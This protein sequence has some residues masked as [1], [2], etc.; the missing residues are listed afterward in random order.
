MAK[1]LGCSVSKVDRLR[2]NNGLPWN[3]E[4]KGTTQEDLERWFEEKIKRNKEQRNTEPE[5]RQD[6]G[7]PEPEGKPY[8]CI[9]GTMVWIDDY[10][11]VVAEGFWK[12]GKTIA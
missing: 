10:G 11:Y 2:K 8:Y 1:F 7:C 12:G 4:Y 5:E 3:Y 6:S 9:D